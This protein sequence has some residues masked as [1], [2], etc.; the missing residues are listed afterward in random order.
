MI[1]SILNAREKRAG[2]IEMLINKHNKPVVSITI[3]IP[4][5]KKTDLNYS[6]ICELAAEEFIEVANEREYEIINY[7]K[8]M[9]GDGPEIF[10]VI[11]GDSLQ[12]KELAVNIEEKHVLGRLFDIDVSGVDRLTLSKSKRRCL[13][14]ND[15]AVNCMVGQRHD[16][17][18][19]F[20]SINRKI[21]LRK[22]EIVKKLTELA[23]RSML[24][25]LSCTPKPGLVDRYNNGA[26]GDMN[27]YTFID[28]SVVLI[29]YFQA[30]AQKSVDWLGNPEELLDNLRTLGTEAET[31]MFIAT[32]GVNTHKDQIFLMG[33]ACAAAANILQR[34]GKVKS[35][36]M[37]D[38]I[39][40]MTKDRIYNELKEK[41][42]YESNGEKLYKLYGLKGARGEA[43]LGFPSSINIGLPS[44]KY[45]LQRGANFNDAMVHCLIN[46]MES[47]DDTNVIHRGG[48][49]GK[50]LIEK[51]IRK[52]KSVGS[53]FTK[54]G[55][56]AIKEL[57]SILIKKHI[58]P[59]GT[60]DMLA[61]TVFLYFIE[62][63]KI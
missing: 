17:S 51:S 32:N 2:Y 59:G 25:E 56:E 5:G 55:I 18:E 21:E 33:L 57:D 20:K 13:V 19:V 42:S 50:E 24:Y 48:F 46:I 7:V 11:E 38:M 49:E 10:I 8:R 4:C 1:K 43:T 23:I 31:D 28:S 36:W 9:S 22:N 16:Y 34:R 61:V 14:C 12:L 3:N 40:K 30:V 41:E 37:S 44:L 52:V 45:A 6:W 58:S 63:I 29:K 53:V 62:K 39:K 47:L 35:Q 54:E 15:I 27:Y 60:A 26:H